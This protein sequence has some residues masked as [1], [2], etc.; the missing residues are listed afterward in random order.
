MRKIS[1]SREAAF[2]ALLYAKEGEF[3]ENYFNKE[4]LALSNKDLRLAKEIAFGTVKRQRSLEYLSEKM[5]TENVFYKLKLKRK[6]KLLLYSA[7]YQFFFLNRIPLYAIVNETVSLAKRYFGHSKAGFFNS[8]LRLLGNSISL[9]NGKEIDQLSY[10]YSYPPFFVEKLI[11]EYGGSKA[12]EILDVQNKVFPPSVRIRKGGSLNKIPLIH[13]KKFKMALA[14]E[15]ISFFCNK[16]S[17]Y[18]QNLTPVLLLEELLLSEIN[19][20]SILDLCASPGGKSIA[21]FDIFPHADF[22]VNDK[23]KKRLEILSENLRLHEVFAKIQNIPAEE[24]I[25]EKKFDLIIVDVPCS[26]SGVLS[27]RHEAR[28]RIDKEN[29]SQ[30][31]L[32]QEKILQ[33]ASKLLSSSGYLLYMTCSILKDEN[34]NIIQKILLNNNLSLEKTHKILPDNFGKDGGFGALLKKI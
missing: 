23:S 13:D 1:N 20:N 17:F 10:F 3:I 15:D 30:L 22:V 8:F 4:E 19:P 16:K 31:C 14:S 21:L 9:P 11:I 6:E 28:W 5:V 24:F 18:I 33:N 25:S 12:E 32:L 7:F 34:E 29:L 2:L 26:N 27:K